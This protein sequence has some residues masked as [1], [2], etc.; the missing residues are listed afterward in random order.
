VNRS[1]RF[2]N[3]A[4]DGAVHR[5]WFVGHFL[6]TTSDLRATGEVEVKWGVH[7]AGDR[8]QAIAMSTEATSLSVLVSGRFRI[9][10]PDQEVILSHPGDY[11]IWGAGVPHGW[12]AEAESVVLTVRWPSQPEDVRE[13]VAGRDMRE[14]AS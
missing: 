6:D 10:F 14:A 1:V 4:L 12:S 9:S 5:G 2:G 3:A 8:R 11:A 13:S 7:P